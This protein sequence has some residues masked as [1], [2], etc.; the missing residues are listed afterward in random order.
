MGFL[1]LKASVSA[2]LNARAITAE[3]E[4]VSQSCAAAKREK[5]IAGHWTICMQTACR[6]KSFQSLVFVPKQLHNGT[7]FK[8]DSPVWPARMSHT[9]CSCCM[10]MKLAYVD[11]TAVKNL[12]ESTESVLISHHLRI[13][14]PSN[15][16]YEATNVNLRYLDSVCIS[17]CHNVCSS[18][19]AV[20][21]HSRD[22]LL[23]QFI[24]GFHSVGASL[25][26]K[27]NHWNT[28]GPWWGKQ[29]EKMLSVLGDAWIRV[30]PHIFAV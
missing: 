24:H 2:S 11:I 21:H 6:N 17:K 8:F 26:N 16:R 5:I 13:R 14:T 7:V 18:A 20:H 22:L 25:Q 10:I 9:T 4:S 15:E 12:N 3:Y 29:V 23:D 27:K 1:L 30:T 19:T 28:N